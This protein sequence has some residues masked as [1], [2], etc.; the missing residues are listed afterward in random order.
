MSSQF[1]SN[2]DLLGISLPSQSSQLAFEMSLAMSHSTRIL[3]QWLTKV[4]NDAG[5]R[6]GRLQVADDGQLQAL[7]HRVGKLRRRGRNLLEAVLPEARVL[8]GRLRIRT[9]WLVLSG[10]SGLRCSLPYR[11][12]QVPILAGSG[13]SPSLFSMLRNYLIPSFGATPSS[14]CRTSIFLRKRL[15][16]AQ[17]QTTINTVID[18]F[19]FFAPLFCSKISLLHIQCTINPDKNFHLHSHHEFCSWK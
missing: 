12:R 5:L 2:L 11:Q 19:T 6:H 13:T 14:F 15:R 18:F 17:I 10:N 9:T 4:V 8:A 1:E 7:V 3:D 16:N